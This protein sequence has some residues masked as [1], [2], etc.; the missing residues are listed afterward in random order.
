M[1]KDSLI[2]WDLLAK[3]YSRQ[4]IA[5][6]AAYRKKLE[7]TQSYFR[8]D[9][10]VM[11]FGCGT[12]STAIIHAPHVRHILATDGS[13]KMIEIAR[14][15]AKAKYIENI[16]FECI[17]I[18]TL[19]LPPESLDVVLGLSILHLLANRDEII[20]KVYTMLK[21][22]GI[23]VTSTA[24]MGDTMPYAK[25]LAP[26]GRL[27]GL[28]VRVFTQAELKN[29]MEQAGFAIDY[30]WSPGLDK[31]AFIIAKKPR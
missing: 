9:M 14:D 11:E 13:E 24:C 10:E 8:P 19:V 26:I 4:P 29:A 1:R 27:I 18:D 23:F 5:D 17:N 15:K 3:R 16:T 2:F 7:V 31:A 21:P 6:E 25:Y 28:T 20:K 30:E 22:G 12:G